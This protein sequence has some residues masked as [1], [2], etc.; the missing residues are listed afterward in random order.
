M[1]QL[2]KYAVLAAGLA[3]AACGSGGSDSLAENYLEQMSMIAAA[4]ESVSD[5]ASVD[6]AATEIGNAIKE[7]EG[8]A[9]DIDKLSPEERQ[10]M[11]AARSADFQKVESR[12]QMAMQ[13][14]MTRNPMLVARINAAMSELPDLN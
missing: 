4:I 6:R 13:S 11:V 7:M 12:L 2:V 14:L 9:A 5:E 1:R 8:L 10:Q 3:L